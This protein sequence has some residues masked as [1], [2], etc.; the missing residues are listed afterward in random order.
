MSLSVGRRTVWLAGAAIL[1]V[2]TTM[3]ML[4][5]SR[6]QAQ[7]APVLPTVKVQAAESRVVSDWEEYSGYLEAIEHVE[8][9]PKVAGTLLGV[10]FRD[11]QIVR[12]GDLLF[13]IDP[14]PFEAEL[15]RAEAV[16][17]QARDRQRFTAS[18]LE[19]GRRLVAARA[20]A[21]GDFDALEVAAQ[22][23]V[24]AVQAARAAVDRARLDVD[25]TRIKA[26][27]SGRISRPEI[28]AGNVVKAGGDAEPL[29]SIV[30]LDPI[31]AAFNI[32]E[33]TYVHNI[34]SRAGTTPLQVN[35]GLVGEDGHPHEGTLYSL[36][37]QLH[38]PSGTIRV[39]ALLANPDARMIPGLQAR[40]RLQVSDPYPA[41]L[42]SE[43]S[44][45]TDQHRR[46]VLVIDPDGRVAQR[47]I[48][49][50][51]RQGAQRVVREGLAPGDQVIVDGA[52]RVRPGDAVQAEP[53]VMVAAND[54]EHAP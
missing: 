16:L 11:G 8:I 43:A 28:T 34:A 14:A 9:R 2:M 15:K 17:A 51:K 42:V 13:T 20:I 37:N 45:A 41:V 10:H 53:A 36:D 22:E 26:P 46:F 54:E 29:A 21:E 3:T 49:L 48:A 24:A 32:D 31:Y 4:P 27:I 23:A 39:R 1:V 6:P 38:T 30:T 35:V 18:E 33:R 47:S 7:Q 52:S 25:Y 19:R 5:P 12:E 44:I 50:G 40:V